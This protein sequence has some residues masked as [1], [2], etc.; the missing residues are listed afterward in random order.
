M[1]RASHHGPSALDFLPVAFQGLVF[2]VP[3]LLVILRAF[4]SGG[5]LDAG[6]DYG[7]DNFTR[8]FSSPRYLHGLLNSCRAG[9]TV[10]GI[11]MMGALPAA[12]FLRFWRRKR[13]SFLISILFLSPLFSSQLLRTF[14]WQS[15]LSTA[16]PLSLL[17]DAAVI[18]NTPSAVLLGLLSQTL[19]VCVVLQLITLHGLHDEELQA[20][21]NLAFPSVLRG[22]LVVLLPRVLEACALSFFT[23]FVLSFLDSINWRLLGGNVAPTLGVL[24]EDRI[25]VQDWGMASVVVLFAVGVSFLSLLL[26]ST[27]L[28]QSFRVRRGSE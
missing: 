8:F 10:A 19:P 4:S 6:E 9:L 16:G 2:G 25:L 13:L 22:G 5:A 15:A 23:A 24:L 20:A 11:S 18:I 28:R 3:F 12:V 14:A 27:L 26:I 1:R 17:G 21:Q 7:L